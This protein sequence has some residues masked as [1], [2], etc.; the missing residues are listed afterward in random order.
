[1]D[2]WLGKEDLF[3]ET[4][5]QLVYSVGKIK[6]AYDLYRCLLPLQTQFMEKHETVSPGVKEITYEDGTVLRVDYNE[7]T[8]HVTY[9]EK[10][11]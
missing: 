6:E 7:E 1:M 9:P 3:C 2:D 11:S 4:N 8:F 10:T 5:E